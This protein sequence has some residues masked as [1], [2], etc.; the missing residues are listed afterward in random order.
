M[1]RQIDIKI[2]RR[3]AYYTSCCNLLCLSS[4]NMQLQ[5]LSNLYTSPATTTPRA[6]R[7]RM[8]CSASVVIRVALPAT[9]RNILPRS[10]FEVPYH[11]DTT[12]SRKRRET[13]C[14]YI[15]VYSYHLLHH[16]S[17]LEQSLRQE[18]LTL[19]CRLL[20]ACWKWTFLP[21]TFILFENGLIVR[22]PVPALSR[23]RQGRVVLACKGQGAAGGA[24]HSTTG[25]AGG[26]LMRILISLY[27]CPVPSRVP[28]FVVSF[29]CISCEI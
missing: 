2:H 13:L 25:R 28:A 23:F 17:P 20:T 1:D 6:T 24:Q 5:P 16:Q 9:I 22:T 4:V 27:S 8:M 15:Y 10:T 12:L 7:H 21:M 11:I 3:A 29:S 19:A 14:F 26:R 18:Y